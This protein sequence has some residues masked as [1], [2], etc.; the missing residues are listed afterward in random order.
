MQRFALDVLG[1]SRARIP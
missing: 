1:A